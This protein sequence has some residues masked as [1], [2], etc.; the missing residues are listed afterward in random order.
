MILW[1]LNLEAVDMKKAKWISVL[2]L[3]ILAVPPITVYATENAELNVGQTGWDSDANGRF[4]LENGERVTGWKKIGSDGTYYHFGEDGYMDIGWFQD[5][6]DNGNWYYLS[7]DEENLGEMQTG[8]LV[9]ETGWKTY[10][11]DCNGRMLH[12]Q[13]INATENNELG[14]PAGLYKLTDDGAVQMNGWAE[15]VT[16]GTYWFMR[17]GDGWFNKDDA[18]CWTS[19][20][21]EKIEDYVGSWDDMNNIQYIHFLMMDIEKQSANQAKITLRLSEG[22]SESLNWEMTGIYDPK[23]GDLNYTDG[24]CTNVYFPNGGQGDPVVTTKYTNGTGKFYMQNG[25]ILWQDNVENMGESSSFG[26][27][28]W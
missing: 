24:R 18:S 28:Q 14:R 25:R 7:R 2:V 15:S 4:Y 5:M 17:A 21:P 6:E 20:L 13:W 12:S 10:Y 22:A 3:G 16:P 1:N 8:W 11:L 9:D 19:G 26:K 23:T 27:D